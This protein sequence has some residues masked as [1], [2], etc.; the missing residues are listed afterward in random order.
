MV[1]CTCESVRYAH[2]VFT[3][4]AEYICTHAY[5]LSAELDTVETLR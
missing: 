5:K 4:V 3:M 1:L 2:L